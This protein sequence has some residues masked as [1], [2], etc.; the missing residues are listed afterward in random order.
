MAWEI[1]AYQ[2][3]QGRQ[4]VT[5]FIASLPQKD[6]ARIYWTLELLRE[7]GLALKMSYARPV[8]G[9]LWEL[10]IQS[11]RNIYRIFYFAH[12]GRRFVLLHAFQKKTRKTPRKELAMAERRL[13]AVLARVEE[14]E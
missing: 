13:A 2:D 6:Q 1:V 10:R 11:G 14:E 9:K 12:T 4:L 8:H 7:F 5:D 3:E